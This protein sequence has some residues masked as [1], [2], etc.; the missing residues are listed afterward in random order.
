MALDTLSENAALIDE[1]VERL[2]AKGS[3]GM[4][5]LE[6]LLQREAEAHTLNAV[7]FEEA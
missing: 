3:L 6:A 7:Q 5:E 1:W 4:K 2:T